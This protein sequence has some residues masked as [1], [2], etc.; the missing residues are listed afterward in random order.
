MRFRIDLKRREALVA[1]GS[2]SGDEPGQALTV[3]KSSPGR[4]HWHLGVGKFFGAFYESFALAQQG[5]VGTI[6]E[7]REHM[8]SLKGR[9]KGQL[10]L[11]LR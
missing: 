8:A 1:S 6:E 10:D 4:G 9:L 7:R 11:L 5:P 2:V 3:P